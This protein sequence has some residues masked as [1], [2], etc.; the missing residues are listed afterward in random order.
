MR[1]L[2]TY[3][4]P[5]SGGE[6]AEL[7]LPRDLT[8]PEADRIKQMLDSLVLGPGSDHPTGDDDG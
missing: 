7:R 5:L 4:F 3:P 6:L 8:Q 1:V 2:Y